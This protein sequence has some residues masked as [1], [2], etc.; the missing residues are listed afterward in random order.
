MKREKCEKKAQAE[1]NDLLSCERDG[2][3]RFSFFNLNN[4]SNVAGM[5]HAHLLIRKQGSDV[6]D[7]KFLCG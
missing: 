1:G 3:L 5:V 2:T 4:E 6:Y 7:E